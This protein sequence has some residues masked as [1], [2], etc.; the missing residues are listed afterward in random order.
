MKPY[1]EDEW[2]T[3]YHGDCQKV[4][5][6]LEAD[7]LVSDVPYGRN[8]KS[9]QRRQTLAR[10]IAGDKDTSLRDWALEQWGDRPALIFGVW[11]I[12]RPPGTHTRLV[13][14]TKGALGMGDLSVPWKPSD[15]EIYV[16]GRGFTGHRGTNVLTCAPVQSLGYNGR[17]HPHEKPVDLM[18]GLIRKCPP[19]VIADPFAGSGT[20]LIAAKREGRKA[21]GVELEEAYCEI[22]AKRIERA[23]EALFGGVA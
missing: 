14:D 8:Y 4:T 13:W 5:E 20:T 9:G 16:L 15:Q 6:W 1:Y 3:L 12:P 21:I 23:P 22:A 11:Q 19:G 7:V 2:V 18:A 17:V 10:S